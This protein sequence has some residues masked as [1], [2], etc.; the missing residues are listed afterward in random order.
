[1][2]KEEITQKLKINPDTKK[3][4]IF[5]LDGTIVFNSI[6]L[7]ETNQNILQKIIDCGHEVIFATGRSHRDFKI[8]MPDQFHSH[9]AVLFSGSVSL[10]DDGKILRSLHIPRTC[11][12]EIIELCQKHKEMY[13]MDNISHYYHPPTDDLTIGF[14]DSQINYYRI[15]EI[16]KML[17]TEIYKIDRK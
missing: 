13:I 8:V 5:D 10:D 14:I 16:L 6:M 12:E 11:V 9:K 2:K 15:T 7:S 1:M 3:C 4:F 17:D